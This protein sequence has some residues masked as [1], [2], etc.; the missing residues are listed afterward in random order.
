MS[1]AQPQPAPGTAPKVLGEQHSARPKRR[2]GFPFAAATLIAIGAVATG[3]AHFAL[4]TLDVDVPGFLGWVDGGVLPLAATIA[5]W[6]WCRSWKQWIAWV[7]L[8]VGLAAF[9]AFTVVNLTV[10]EHS[11]SGSAAPSIDACDARAAEI[12]AFEEQT[13]ELSVAAWEL[14]A[15]PFNDAGEYA[16]SPPPPASETGLFADAQRLNTG[17]WDYWVAQGGPQLEQQ[18]DRL[19]TEYGMLCEASAP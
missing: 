1:E 17:P 12:A 11:L 8:P 9:V 3:V 10:T 15:S 16:P 18:R 7:W 13:Q 4:W 2:S 5:M 19:R 14:D 6:I